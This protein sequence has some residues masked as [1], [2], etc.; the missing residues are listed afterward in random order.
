[1]VSPPDGATCEQFVCTASNDFDPFSG[2]V[3]IDYIPYS[4]LTGNKPVLTKNQVEVL[5]KSL[6]AIKYYFYKRTYWGMNK[7]YDD[8]A[9]D[10]E[11]KFTK[12]GKL[13]IKQARPY[14]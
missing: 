2:G 8:F 5:Y 1:M 14:N 4:S 10:I 7:D 13:Y 9:L 12:N 3:N 6:S 11:F